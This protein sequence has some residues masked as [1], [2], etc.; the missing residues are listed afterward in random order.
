MQKQILCFAY[1]TAPGPKG[2]WLRMTSLETRKVLRGLAAE[3]VGIEAGL[4]AG[5]KRE[6]AHVHYAF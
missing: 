3:G 6:A 1:R 5:R 4:R 2:A